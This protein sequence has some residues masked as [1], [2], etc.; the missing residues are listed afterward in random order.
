MLAIT[1]LRIYNT[2]RHWIYFPK[3]F[4]SCIKDH[5]RADRCYHL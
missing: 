3:Y 1:P 5:Q 4:R 2:S